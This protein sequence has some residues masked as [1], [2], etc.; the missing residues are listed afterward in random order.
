MNL[1]YIT[2]YPCTVITAASC[3]SWPVVCFIAS[4]VVV[5]L[6]C[7]RCVCLSL[8]Y[9]LLPLLLSINFTVPPGSMLWTLLSLAVVKVPLLLLPPTTVG[10]AFVAS[11]LHIDAGLR[12][13]WSLHYTD[14]RWAESPI[15]CMMTRE[16]LNFE[17]LNNR[18]SHK[19]QTFPVMRYSMHRGR[20]VH[21][22]FISQKVS[23]AD[24]CTSVLA[25]H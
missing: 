18:K 8:E 11:H 12:A 15:L 4:A 22:A 19:I 13:S 6:L 20:C 1:Q 2:L 10:G 3:Q 5:L 17:L 23:A 7:C 9:W 25:V 14:R 21:S 16:K 24:L